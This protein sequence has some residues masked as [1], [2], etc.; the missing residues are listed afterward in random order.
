MD[1]GNRRFAI[2]QGLADQLKFIREG[3][4]DERAGSP[5]LKLIGDVKVVSDETQIVERVEERAITP[6]DAL[7]V[8]LMG[9]VV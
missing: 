9:R 5:T 7:M 2:D 6:D 4:F 3:E 1:A 8:Y